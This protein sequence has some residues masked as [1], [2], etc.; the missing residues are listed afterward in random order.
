MTQSTSRT[1]VPIKLTSEQIRARQRASMA[2]LRKH[3]RFL[4]GLSTLELFT[5]EVSRAMWQVEGNKYR[6]QIAA[7]AE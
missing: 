7:R 5:A 3:R 1:S 6:T 2:K 4:G